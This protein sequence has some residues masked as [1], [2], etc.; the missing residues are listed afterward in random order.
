M[1]TATE[2]GVDFNTLSGLIDVNLTITS[3][4]L[5]TD[6]SFTASFDYGTALNPI[7]FSGA[8]VGDFQLYNNSTATLESIGGLVENSTANYTLSFAFVSL[9][10]YTLT[11]LKDGFAGSVTFDAN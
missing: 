6:I 5:N 11:L 8:V 3:Q 1:I 9:E 4:T 2:A 10:N 7:L